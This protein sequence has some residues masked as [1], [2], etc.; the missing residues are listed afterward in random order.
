M[1]VR[2]DEGSTL[3]LV[4]GFGLLCLALVLLVAAATSLYLERKRLFTVA[5]GAALAG[6]EAYDLDAIAAGPSGPQP[7]LDSADVAAAVDT[8]LA[9]SPDRFES[10][11]V[12][13]A[14]ALDAA[15]A[16]VTLSAYWRPPVLTLLVPEG[17]RIEVTAVGRTVFF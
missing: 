10:L 16:T 1:R 13:H 3:P 15:S 8:Y 11:A 6:A 5:D 14:A 12:E 7:A 4:I 17:F 9:A 2:D